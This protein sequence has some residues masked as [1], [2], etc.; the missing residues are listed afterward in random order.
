MWKLLRQSIAYGWSYLASRKL[1]V[2]AALFIPLFCDFFFLNLMSEGLPLRVPAAVVDLDHST[3]SRRV[4]RN[5][6]SSELVDLKYAEESFHDAMTKIRNGEIFGFFEI[7]RDFQKNAMNGQ[8]T[9]ITFYSD[10]TVFV[11][12]TL[13]FKGFKTTAVTTAG[14]VAVTTLTS[15]GVNEQTAGTL[16]QPVVVDQ[17]LLGNPWTNYSIYLSNSFLPGVLALMIV[18]VACYT[19]CDEIKFG[20]SVDWL[21]ASGGSMVTALVG[22]LLPQTVLFTALGWFMQALLFGYSH[23]PM[24]CPAWQMMMAMVLLVLGCQGFAV[25]ICCI[26]PNLRLSLIFGALTGIL[27]FSIAAYSFPV[28]SMYGGVAIFSY[29]LPVRYYFLTYTDLALNGTPLFYARFYLAAML[30]FVIL[31]FPLLGRLRRR[32]LNPV[33]VP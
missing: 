19:I 12:G 31:P 26:V 14:G 4:T 11:P 27:A 30:L 6:S 33:Y 10:L 16:L 23:F 18:L 22:K 5:L 9:T 15:L 24:N 17:R 25:L 21:R 1:F 3:L 8:G 2:G 7:P 13:V 20:T 28:Q 32:C 29:I